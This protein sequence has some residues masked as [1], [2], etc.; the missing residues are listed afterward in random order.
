MHLAWPPVVFPVC[1]GVMQVCVCGLTFA[2]AHTHIQ[3]QHEV[4]GGVRWVK[5]VRHQRLLPRSS[6]RSRH[7]DRPDGHLEVTNREEIQIFTINFA[8]FPNISTSPEILFCLL[9]LVFINHPCPKMG[10]AAS[11]SHE[12]VA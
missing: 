8:H 12:V 4:E 1:M 6:P 11:G 2:R 5:A 9:C 10:A 3:D 7:C